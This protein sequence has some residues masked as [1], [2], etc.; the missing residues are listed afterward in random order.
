MRTR[1]AI[2]GLLMVGA[3]FSCSHVPV[4]ANAVTVRAVGLGDTLRVV[5]QFREPVSVDSTVVVVSTRRNTTDTVTI[6]LRRYGAA[7]VTVRDSVVVVPVVPWNG[8]NTI[9]VTA[10]AS[11]YKSGTQPQV[12]GACLTALYVKPLTLGPVPLA[13]SLRVQ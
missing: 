5:Y 8:G 7:V 4:Y 10:C 1:T 12:P 11:A 6:A 13:D 3:W 9:Q 2:I